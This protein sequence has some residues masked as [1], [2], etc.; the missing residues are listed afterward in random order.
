MN[1][2]LTITDAKLDYTKRAEP[3]TFGIITEDINEFD[4]EHPGCE[5]SR[6]RLWQHQIDW[7]VKKE[8]K[9]KALETRPS[10]ESVLIGWDPVSPE[11]VWP[12]MRCYQPEY[13]HGIRVETA[14][15]LTRFTHLFSHNINGGKVSHLP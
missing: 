12:Y 7:L 6:I 1:G 15:D 9:G 3:L 5:L 10:D 11:G 2:K 8:R 4:A 14:M 13:I